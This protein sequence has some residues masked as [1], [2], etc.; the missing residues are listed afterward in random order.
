MFNEDTDS[1]V[2]AK[3][4]EYIG[5]SPT[6]IQANMQ[7]TQ[8][9]GSC[10]IMGVGLIKL[11]KHGHGNKDIRYSVAWLLCG[12]ITSLEVGYREA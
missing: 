1:N 9:T 7:D 8:A 5:F 2:P 4:G 6:T 11:Y 3:F 12:I 10:C